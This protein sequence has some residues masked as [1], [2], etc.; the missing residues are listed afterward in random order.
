MPGCFV[1]A[2]LGVAVK[3]RPG[4]ARRGWA[5]FGATVKARRDFMRKSRKRNNRRDRRKAKQSEFRRDGTT[6]PQKHGH[7]SYTVEVRK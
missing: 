7:H 5:G 3:E 1:I 6:N 2:R 4:K